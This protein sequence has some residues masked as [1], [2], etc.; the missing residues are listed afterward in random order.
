MK[1]SVWLFFLSIFFLS[2]RMLFA[3]GDVVGIWKTVNDRMGFTTSI[4]AVYKFDNKTYGRVIVAFDEETGVLIDTIYN[5]RQIIAGTGGQ[6][7]LCASNLFWGLDWNGSR[8]INGLLIDP[9]NGKVYRC[10]LWKEDGVLILRGFWGIFGLNQ[11]LYPVDEE[12][13]PMGFLVPEITK[14]VPVIPGLSD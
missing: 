11:I 10:Q 13:Y 3:S 14:F 9:R 5:P 8:W 1:R 6:S 2:S 7:L 12:D 4:I